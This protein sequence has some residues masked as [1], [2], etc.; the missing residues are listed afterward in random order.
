MFILHSYSQ[1]YP[2]TKSQH[3]GFVDTLLKEHGNFEIYTEH[4]DTK[5]I[6]L[7]DAYQEEMIHY[8]NNKYVSSKIDLLYVTDDNA[9]SF[10]SQNHHKIFKNSNNPPIFFSGINNLDIDSKLDKNKFVGVYEVKEITKN[11]ELIKQ[12][13]PQTRDIYFL[14][15]G[16]KTYEAIKKSIQ[17][18]EANFPSMNFHYIG[19]KYMANIQAKLPT[20]VKSFI[21]LTTIGELKDTNEKT[22]LL[23]E[24]ISKIKENPNLIL[25]SMEDAY[26]LKGVVGGYVTDGHSQGREAAN[27][28]LKYLR[29]NSLQNISSLKKSPNIY[30]FN[31]QELNNARIYLSEYI[32]RDATI[33]NLDK[34]FLDKHQSNLLSILAT[35][36]IILSISMI[37]GYAFFRKK[38][39]ILL[40]KNHLNEL[41]ILKEKLDMKDQ[42]INTIMNFKRLGYWRL[43]TKNNSLF[44]SPNILQ[45]LSIDQFIYQNDFHTIS[46]FIHE[47]DKNLYFKHFDEVLKQ[48]NST[49]FVHKMV[50][51]EKVVCE[52]KHTIYMQYTKHNTSEILIGIIEFENNENK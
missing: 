11:I 9:L 5:R 34:S 15:D 42:F 7:S 46:Y 29:E 27:L 20:K 31:H 13:S 26:M 32:K 36:I 24:S 41:A 21:L 51:S 37:L 40:M 39:K 43:D 44:I 28:A 48:K 30:I 4:L 17:K 14:G 25:L 12:F 38:I 8:I 3:N 49:T 19:D 6:E 22:L 47:H 52:V 1:E 45:K 2:W 33:I 23:Q 10:L 50:S 35:L 18:E 16:S